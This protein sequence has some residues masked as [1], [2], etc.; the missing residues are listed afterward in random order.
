M[1]VTQEKMFPLLIPLPPSSPQNS[2]VVEDSSPVRNGDVVELVHLGT[3]R[4]LNSHDV[5]APLSP[6][7]QE[8]AGYINYSAQFIPYLQW[9][10]VGY[11]ARAMG[12]A[13]ALQ[14]FPPCLRM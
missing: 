12:G 3:D 1:G 5:A 4:L 8:V 13:F 14:S 6:A 9:Q 11:G 7:L 2:S 10:L